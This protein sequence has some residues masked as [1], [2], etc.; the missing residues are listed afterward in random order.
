MYL[1]IFLRLL[2]NR[3][4]NLSK[5]LLAFEIVLTLVVIALWSTASGVI[6]ARFNGTYTHTIGI[7]DDFDTP[8]VEFSSCKRLNVSTL[9]TDVSFDLYASSRLS[10]KACGLANAM[11]IVG[12][13]TIIAWLATL[14][15]SIYAL[16]EVNSFALGDLFIM[17]AP[18][19]PYQ[20]A[21]VQVIRKDYKYSDPVKNVQSIT[22]AACT[23]NG[24][25]VT[26]AE[27][28]KVIIAN[29]GETRK[30]HYT[31]QQHKQPQQQK[32]GERG[33][34]KSVVVADNLQHHQPHE[35][36]PVNSIKSWNFDFSFEPVQI[37]LMLPSTSE[38]IGTKKKKSNSTNPY[39][40][41]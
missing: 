29:E 38:L 8:N 2:G 25:F 37:D 15:A 12:F 13:I 10:S 39:R 7:L 18:V 20:D 34:R 41:P 17:Q 33:F 9:T 24:A 4:L 19:H 31:Q 5:R 35:L 11:I 3:P 23:K 16:S 32:Q 22:T 30:L 21:K 36:K 28:E 1:H 26:T 6:F 14:V 40:Y 27:P